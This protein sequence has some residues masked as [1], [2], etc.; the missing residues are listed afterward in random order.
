MSECSPT[1]VTLQREEDPCKPKSYMGLF[2]NQGYPFKGPSNKDS[3]ILRF[4]L[5]SPHFGKLPNERRTKLL[6]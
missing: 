1:Q 3:K 5:G 2:K 6:P 4:I